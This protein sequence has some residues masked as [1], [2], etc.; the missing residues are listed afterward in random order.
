MK[1]FNNKIIKDEDQIQFL[2]KVND[3]YKLYVI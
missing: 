2:L 3:K 1:E